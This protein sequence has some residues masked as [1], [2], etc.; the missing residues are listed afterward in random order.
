MVS[1]NGLGFGAGPVSI[2]GLGGWITLPIARLDFNGPITRRLD[3]AAPMTRSLAFDG[4]LVRR[5][6]LAGSLTRQMD[7][8][9]PLVRELALD[10]P[11]RGRMQ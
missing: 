4:A 7:F 5:L 6:D 2:S 8:D 1:V 3:L 10:G 11:I 9:G